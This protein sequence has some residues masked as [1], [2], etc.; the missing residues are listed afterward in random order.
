MIAVRLQGRLGNQLF[1]YAFIF[2]ASK[3]IDTRFYLDQCLEKSIVHQYFQIPKNN[4]ETLSFFLNNISGYKNI[5]NYHLRKL[6]NECF[7]YFN[8]FKIKEYPFGEEGAN[9]EY[10]NKTLYAGNFQSIL[11]MEPYENI[12]RG[13]LTIKKELSKYFHERF[14]SLYKN[15]TIVTV[16]VRRTDYKN[17]KHLN[18][19]NHDLSL[20]LRYYNNALLELKKEFDFKKDNLH[21]VFISDDA[22]FVAQN[23][24]DF[25]PKT[26]SKDREIF[27]FQHLLNSDVCIISNSSFSWWGAWLNKKDKIIY[28]PKYYLGFHLKK[29]IP[30]NIYPNEWRQIEFN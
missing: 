6:I 29:Q 5:F 16:H 11:F 13:K 1:Q 8:H 22:E 26:I 23:F 19:G 7:V 25:E 27:D 17:L 2:A 9:I 15:K 30:E 20:P 10:T 28:C 4:I 18:L 12:I 14:G 21:F 24:F 3:K